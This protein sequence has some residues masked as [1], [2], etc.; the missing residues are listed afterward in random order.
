MQLVHGLS[1][2]IPQSYHRL[3][4]GWDISLL[5]RSVF[6][7]YRNSCTSEYTSCSS[8]A[9]LHLASTSLTWGWLDYSGNNLACHSYEPPQS[10]GSG[11]SIWHWK[12]NMLLLLIGSSTHGCQNPWKIWAITHSWWHVMTVISLDYLM[13]MGFGCF[14]KGQTLHLYPVELFQRKHAPGKGPYKRPQH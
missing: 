12:D 13:L 9:V 14:W 10:I 11:Q 7:S 5:T 3:A 6:G 1:L 2:F 8:Y 4:I